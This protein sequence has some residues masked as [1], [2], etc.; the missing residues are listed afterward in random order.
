[1]GVAAICNRGG[2]T[3]EDLGVPCLEAQASVE[4]EAFDANNCPLCAANK[5]I[6]E[7]IGHGASYK[8]DHPKYAGGYVRLLS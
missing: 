7:D 8:A 4:F 6:V 1:M 3:A 5:P 2:A